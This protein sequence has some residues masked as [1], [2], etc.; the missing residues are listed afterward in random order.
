MRATNGGSMMKKIMTWF[1]LAVTLLLSACGTA[2]QEPPSPAQTSASGTPETEITTPEP[3]KWEGKGYP[4]RQQALPSR[5]DSTVS[6]FAAGDDYYSAIMY[7]A[8]DGRQAFELLKNGE[9][10]IYAPADTYITCASGGSE[11]IWLLESV[12]TELGYEGRLHLIGY[13]SESLRTLAMADMG[14]EDTY[15]Y[16]MRCFDGGLCLQGS[17]EAAIIDDNGTLEAFV[18]FDAP[19][20]Y[21]V[22]GGDGALYSVYAGESSNA[23]RRYDNG[24]FTDALDISADGMTVFGGNSEFLLTGTLEDGLYGINSDG[25]LTPLIIWEECRVSVSGL[26]GIVPLSE[27]R[28]LL[29]DSMGTSMLSPADP[30]ELKEPVVLTIA[31]LGEGL[32]GLTYEFNMSSTDYFLEEVDYSDGG[33]L[34]TTDALTRLSTDIAAGNAPDMFLLSGIPVNSWIRRGYLADMMPIIEGDPSFDL[35][36][37][38]ISEQLSL[39]GGLY[40]LDSSFGIDTYAALTSNLG[41]ALG[42]TLEEYLEAETSLPAGSIMMYNMT[43]ELFFDQVSSRYMQRAIDWQSGSCDFDNEDFVTLL[44]S[45]NAIRETPEPEEFSGYVPAEQALREG[46]EYAVALWI[47]NVTQIKE[48]ESLVGEPISVVGMPTPDGGCGS[49]LMM[50]SPVGIYA[51]S[52][53]QEGCWEFMKYLLMSYDMDYHSGTNSYMPVY[54]TYFDAQIERAM[55]ENGGARFSQADAQRLQGLIDAVDFTTL[56]DETAHDI[57]Q[58]EASAY[59]NGIRSAEEAAEIIQSRLSIYVAEQG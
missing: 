8:E 23:V 43:K 56:Y 54:R 21:V 40:Y 28:F 16:S 24:T 25:S 44:E 38:V 19:E 35:D 49:R 1:L 11:G 42:W 33:S 2:Q 18:T 36:D 5:A 34:S 12:R 29:L 52:D 22:T 46:T 45:A 3:V 15:F 9:E 55:N 59:F 6:L 7:F 41:D 37:I 31:T 32:Y 48:F 39:D 57:I 17:G 14:L 51:G 53:E 27:G 26:R 30:A 47:G 10:L 4:Y 58:E 13:D 50:N 20:T